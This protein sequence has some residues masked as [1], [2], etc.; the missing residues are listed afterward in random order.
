MSQR[1]LPVAV[2]GLGVLVCGSPSSPEA[3]APA[4]RALTTESSNAFWAHWG[5]GRAEMNGYRL[6]QPR[7]GAPR[8]GSAVYIFV[9][10]D[11]SDSVRVKA[12]PG[13]HPA[14]DVYPVMKLNAVRH[15]QTGI[16]DYNDITPRIWQAP[17]SG[18]S[19]A[20]FLHQRQHYPEMLRRLFASKAFKSVDE[21]RKLGL[22]DNKLQ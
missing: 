16:Y 4:G 6:V 1:L 10:E 18:L 3:A 13:R 8:T 12:D 22:D 21:M 15:F 20:S 11:F 5:D 14:S 9:T 19:I 7:Y 17:W 2:L